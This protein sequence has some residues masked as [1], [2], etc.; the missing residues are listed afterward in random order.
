MNIDIK[1]I[2]TLSDDIKYAVV[3]KTNYNGNT[4]YYLVDIINNKNVKFC[5]EENQ[6]LVEVED[7]N[8]LKTIIPKLYNVI[9]DML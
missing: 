5:L 6:Y 7:E 4:Y 9:K 1:D 8:V 3:S 2:F